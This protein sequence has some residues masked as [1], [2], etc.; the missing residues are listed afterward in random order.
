MCF[1]PY[2]MPL[3]VL[4]I[5]TVHVVCMQ[6]TP[7][8]C[9][10]CSYH[11][12]LPSPGTLSFIPLHEY[13]CLYPPLPPPPVIYISML[14]LSVVIV[15]QAC[16]YMLKDDRYSY[17]STTF[18][19]KIFLREHIFSFQVITFN[20]IYLKYIFLIHQ[21]TYE[22]YLEHTLHNGDISNNINNNICPSQ[23]LYYKT[24]KYFNILAFC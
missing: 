22:L 3:L 18:R 23:T 8:L 7:W 24:Y 15:H 17:F 2:N 21:L 20:I 12:A 19:E 11:Q 4:K 10:T 6:A 5:R 1:L 14:W 9:I 13:A 16:V